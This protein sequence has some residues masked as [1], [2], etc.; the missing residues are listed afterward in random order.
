MKLF[1]GMSRRDQGFP[2]HEQSHYLLHGNGTANNIADVGSRVSTRPNGLNTALR[3]VAYLCLDHIASAVSDNTLCSF[4]KTLDGVCAVHSAGN[5]L[6]AAF[7]VLQ[8]SVATALGVT[9]P[10][11]PCTIFIDVESVGPDMSDKDVLVVEALPASSHSSYTTIAI[12][13]QKR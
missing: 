9:R 2:S 6:P 12:P 7:Q 4:S 8:Y 3:L 1:F 13:V 5:K 11:P 10:L